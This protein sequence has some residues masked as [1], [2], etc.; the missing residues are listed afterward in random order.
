MSEDGKKESKYDLAKQRAGDLGELLDA[1]D[2]FQFQAYA[3]GD[4]DALWNWAAA[5]TTLWDNYLRTRMDEDTQEKYDNK[6]DSL[7]VDFG[8]DGERLLADK[9]D[10]KELHRELTEIRTELNLDIPSK[11][12]TDESN[13]FLEG[14]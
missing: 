1:L 9:S 2:H 13:S 3:K 4:V 7:F 11:D 6:I 8:D 5:L 14:L 12:E 10:L